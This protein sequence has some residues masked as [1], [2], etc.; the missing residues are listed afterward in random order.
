[1]T[2]DLLCC[3]SFGNWRSNNEPVSSSFTIKQRHNEV[4]LTCKYCEK[5]FDR[6]AVINNM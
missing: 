3:I 1:M 2:K 5:T 6:H 4:I